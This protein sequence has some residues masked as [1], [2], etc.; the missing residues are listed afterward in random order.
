MKLSV[1]YDVSAS[2][3]FSAIQKVTNVL[4][5]QSVLQNQRVERMK[6]LLFVNKL[7]KSHVV[8]KVLFYLFV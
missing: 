7:V 3:G 6:S 5:R 8:E 2:P 1:K 4:N